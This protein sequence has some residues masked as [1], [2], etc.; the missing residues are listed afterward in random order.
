MYV[1]LSDSNLT[2]EFVFLTP[3][4]RGPVIL[5]LK[6]CSYSHSQRMM[7]QE[8]SESYGYWK[9]P[10]V[11][12]Y[13]RFYFFNLTN[14]EGVWSLKEKPDFKEMGPYT[15]REHRLKV[16]ITWNK[17]GTVSYQQIK[18]WYFESDL[19]DGSL[20]D[21]VTTLNVPAVVSIVSTVTLH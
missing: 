21:I 9:E 10:P 11:P 12:I 16:N 18:S 13:I 5:F 8:G 17:N 4:P 1:G 6:M 3:L 2:S 15:F 20:E 14:P 7:L 19:T